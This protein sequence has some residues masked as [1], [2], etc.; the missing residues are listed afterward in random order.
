M[1]MTE[2]ALNLV[3]NS[4]MSAIAAECHRLAC[5][6]LKYPD[7]WTVQTGWLQVEMELLEWLQEAKFEGKRNEAERIEYG[8]LLY[9]VLSLGAHMGYDVE[10]ELR[11]AM[12]RNRERAE[13]G[14]ATD[15]R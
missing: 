9:T 8:D 5:L 4:G 3:R 12:Q 13:E 6:R 2:N 15:G 14:G 10:K 1:N 7:R 11:D